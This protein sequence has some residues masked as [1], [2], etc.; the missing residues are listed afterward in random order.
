MSGAGKTSVLKTLEDLGYESV[1]H[2]PLSLLHRLVPASPAAAEAG[3][4]A[5]PLALGMDVRTR[6]FRVEAALRE[7]DRLVAGSPGGVR[8]LFLDCDDEELR[9]RYTETRHRHPLAA[10]RPVADG[11]ALERRLLFP[12]RARADIVVDTSGLGLGALKR[13]LESHFGLGDKPDLCVFVTSFSFRLGLPREADLVFDVR[14]LANPHYDPVLRDKTGLDATVAQ[15][16]E[17]DEGFMPFVDALTNLIGPLLPR[18]AAEGKS[19][20][21]IGVGCTGGRHRSVFVAQVLT[22]RLQ[23]LGFSVQVR[24]RDV[25]RRSTPVAAGQ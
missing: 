21:T 5:R 2:L 18:Y 6:D 22:S 17:R 3:S 25:N 10:D 23:G 15:Y 9:R 8:L 14:F 24:H 13:I 20:L 19:Y 7:I 1:D 12:L 4:N 11:I 16:I